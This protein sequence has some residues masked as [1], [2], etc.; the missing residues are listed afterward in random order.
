MITTN[1]VLTEAD[2]EA[3]QWLIDSSRERRHFDCDRLDELENELRRAKVVEPCEVPPDVVTMNS[4]VRIKDLDS[5]R[6]IT[7]QLVFPE[8][9]SLA[10]NQ[11]SILAPIGTALIGDRAGSIVHWR[12]PS[13]TRRFQILEVEY[14]PE[15][16][17]RAIGC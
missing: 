13:G 4:R 3:L 12:V 14:Q 5:G 17:I 9:A 15:A 16:A 8:D 6:A 11:I 10:Q 1:L 2:R 7:Y